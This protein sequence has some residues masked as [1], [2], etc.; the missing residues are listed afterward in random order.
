M[1]QN[2]PN[3]ISIVAL[4]ASLAALGVSVFTLCDKPATAP[5][6]ETA[7]QVEEEAP[8]Q[9]IQYVLYLG[10]N[11]KDTNEPVFEE[12]EARAHAEA[13]LTDHFGGFTI[14]EARGGWVNDDGS[15]AHEYT[16]VIHLSDT[17]L[18]EVHAACNDLIAEFNQSSILI[19]QNLT[20][21][22]FYSGV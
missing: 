22:E 9:D 1:A 11:D 17:N 14:Q 20:S 16:I 10:T 18:D 15:I 5:A 3:V 13:I 4:L 19:Q 12:E 6:Q 21:T 8:A 2:K 7:P